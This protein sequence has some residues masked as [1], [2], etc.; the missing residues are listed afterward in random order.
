MYIDERRSLSGHFD[1]DCKTRFLSMSRSP[2]NMRFHSYGN[3][4]NNLQ[5]ISLTI[6]NCDIVRD[7]LPVTLAHRKLLQKLQKRA[8]PMTSFII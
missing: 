8:A 7:N 2:V 5:W 1:S 4:F 6:T 3:M